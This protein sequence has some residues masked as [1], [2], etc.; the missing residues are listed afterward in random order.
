MLYQFM[1]P[2]RSSLSREQKLV[3]SFCFESKASQKL[4]P[5]LRT[6]AFKEIVPS[7][8]RWIHCNLSLSGTLTC[9]LHLFDEL[10]LSA[11]QHV[12]A[13]CA[14][15]RLGIHLPAGFTP[16]KWE[17]MTYSVH[18]KDHR[19]R[20]VSHLPSYRQSLGTSLPQSR[21]FSRYL[22]RQ[23]SISH[24][25]SYIDPLSSKSPIISHDKCSWLQVDQLNRVIFCTLLC[26]HRRWGS[27][28]S[29]SM[30]WDI[31]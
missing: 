4:A 20:L 9:R 23:I 2:A 3:S 13:S 11:L 14:N 18:Y 22:V 12:R 1:L 26:A 8:N 16:S 25:A 24:A 6:R 29:P 17:L 7:W 5:M 31:I 19:R 27:S 15:C 21:W 28:R 10:C 30:L